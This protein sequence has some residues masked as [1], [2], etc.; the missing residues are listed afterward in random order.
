MGATKMITAFRRPSG[1]ACGR[2]IRSVL[3]SLAAFA[4][5]WPFG[6]VNSVER[7]HTAGFPDAELAVGRLLVASKSLDS[8]YF[9]H[10]VVLLIKHNKQGTVGIVVNQPTVLSLSSMSPKLLHGDDSDLLYYG[11]PV[12]HML[13]SMLVGSKSKG[14]DR[15]YVLDDI[16]HV[17]GIRAIMDQ[18]PKLGDE[19]TVRV[20]AGYAG[21]GPG[22]LGNEIARGDWHVAPGDPA[23]IFSTEPEDIW[24]RL[25]DEFGGYWL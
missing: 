23:V 19:D 3:L 11:G 21:W 25:V 12:Q 13:F 20:Y 10:T 2:W 8:P 7:F 22:Q 18:I 5:I 9:R 4:T 15:T 17:A 6:V 1:A 24:K 16:Y 14:A